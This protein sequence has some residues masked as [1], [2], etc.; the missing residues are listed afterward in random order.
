MERKEYLLSELPVELRDA[1]GFA[2]MGMGLESMSTVGFALDGVRYR[3][4]R[5]EQAKAKAKAFGID[6]MDALKGAD[7]PTHEVEASMDRL[8]YTPEDRSQR[9]AE[10]TERRR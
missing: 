1:A 8:G 6:L 10:I 7:V 2:S 3:I 5:D 9:W 4:Y